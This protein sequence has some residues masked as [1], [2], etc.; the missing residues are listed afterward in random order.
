MS[1][2]LR[3]AILALAAAAPLLA[4]AQDYPAREIHSICNFSVG[5]G[6]DMNGT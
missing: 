4:A 2:A 6:A 5:S 3:S 1:Q